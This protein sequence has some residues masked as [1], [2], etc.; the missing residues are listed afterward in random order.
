MAILN[1]LKPATD[2]VRDPQEIKEFLNSKG[3]SFEQWQA[4]RELRDDADQETILAAYH[5]PLSTY[6]QTHG[7]LQADVI[8]VHAG[9][10]NIE[11]VRKKFL[12][13]HTHAEDEVRFFVDGEGEFFFHLEG[14]VFSVLCQKGDFLSVPKG[15]THWFDL[16]PGYRVKAIRVFQSKEGWVAQYTG[17]A[18][19]DDYVR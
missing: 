17:S 2:S 3:I 15:Y 6:M 5:G 14:Q 13:E 18:I 1:K 9:T 12:S 16:A 4:D 7:Y 10:P 11:E 8:N 19:A